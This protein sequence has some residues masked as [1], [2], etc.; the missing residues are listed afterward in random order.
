MVR[1]VHF[2]VCSVGSLWRILIHKGSEMTGFKFLTRILIKDNG[3]DW[4]VA[5]NE[6]VKSVKNIVIIQVSGDGTWTIVLI[7]K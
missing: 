1:V 2:S 6:V 4:K 3:T 5:R 7:A